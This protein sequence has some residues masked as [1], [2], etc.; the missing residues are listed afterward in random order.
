MSVFLDINKL[1]KL[2][3]YQVADL[4]KLLIALLQNQVFSESI[5]NAYMCDQI[6]H[7]SLSNA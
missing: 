6:Y 4:V 3:I 1:F 7:F 2:Q 5:T